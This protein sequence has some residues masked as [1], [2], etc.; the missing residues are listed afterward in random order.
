MRFMWRQSKFAASGDP[1]DAPSTGYVQSRKVME[2]DVETALADYALNATRL[3]YI[4]TPY[5]LIKL[6]F[7]FRIANNI[8]IPEV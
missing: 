6:T 5:D 1:C 7:Q 4:M 3:Y 2:M 8:D